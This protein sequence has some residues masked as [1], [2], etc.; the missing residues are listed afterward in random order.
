M[1]NHMST[2]YGYD[3]YV[4][5]ICTIQMDFERGNLYRNKLF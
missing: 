3:K 1:Y 2:N 5:T 4:R